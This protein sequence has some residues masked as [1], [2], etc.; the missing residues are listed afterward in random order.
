[1]FARLWVDVYYIRLFSFYRVRALSAPTPRLLR[2]ARDPGRPRAPDPGRESS[3]QKAAPATRP[4]AALGGCRIAAVP[5]T[6][7]STRTSLQ[8][9]C[10]SCGLR[11][12][13]ADCTRIRGATCGAKYAACRCAGMCRIA[14]APHPRSFSAGHAPL[15][16]DRFLVQSKKICSWTLRVCPLPATTMLGRGVLAVLALGLAGVMADGSVPEV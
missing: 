7:T 15:D 12:S 2:R 3:A 9:C 8:G 11:G 1:M 14:L 6:C 13:G 5:P 4:T 10:S 16:F